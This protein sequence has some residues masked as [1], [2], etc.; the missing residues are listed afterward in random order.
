MET[1]S[2]VEKRVFAKIAWRLVP[3]LAVANVFN[4]VDRLNIGFAALTMNQDVGLTA[5]QFGA[6]AG[7]LFL[8]YCSCG[9]PSNLALYRFGARI[10]ITLLV[11]TWG[12]VSAA[13]CFVSG[14]VSWYLLRVLLGVAEAGF[15][16]GVTYLIGTWFPAEYRAR[17]LAWFLLAV[18]VSSIISGPVSGLLLKMDGIA[19]IAGWQWLFLLEGLPAALV[20]VAIPWVI[21]DRPEQ[22]RWLTEGERQVVAKRIRG[23]QRDRPVGR[24]LPAMKDVRVLTL[25][26]VQ[27]GFIVGAYGVGVWL[28][29]IIKAG[30]FSDLEVGF[31]T[32]GCYVVASIGMFAWS[33][34][35]DRSGRR[36]RHLTLACLAAAVGSILAILTGNFWLSL[37]WLTVALIGITAARTIFWA[38]PARFLT[39]LAAAGGIAFINSIGTTGGFVG[40]ALIGWLKDQTGSFSAGLLAMA[41]IL[42]ISTVMAWSLRFYVKH[43]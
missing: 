35:V 37:T 8:G 40:P 21:V 7:I 29:Q 39:G 25:A 31:V 30:H 20:G 13:T 5:T 4:F 12:L 15:F 17:I 42:L 27:F 38:I 41:G 9:F 1:I 14:P 43:E 22:A 18:P 10:W 36:I 19:G 11:V 34:Y 24:L 33:A 26:V 23:E 2:E 3:I 28:P 32:G 6:G 16:P